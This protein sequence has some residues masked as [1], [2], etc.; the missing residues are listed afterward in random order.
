[1]FVI[2]VRLP[3]LFGRCG[4]LSLLGYIYIHVVWCIIFALYGLLFCVVW[5]W[6]QMSVNM[7]P[8]GKLDA[9]AH[10]LHPIHH[11][12]G[13]F[14]PRMFLCYCKKVL[15][16]R[17]LFLPQNYMVQI[18]IFEKIFEKNEKFRLLCCV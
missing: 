11:D 7:L 16:G 1:M 8:D 14:L 15:W 2:C 12:Q 6:V 4:F 17:G 13:V 10:T 3:S 18:P 5:V 9:F